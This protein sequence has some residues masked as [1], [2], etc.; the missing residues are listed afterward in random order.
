MV[1]KDCLEWLRFARMD[2]TAAQDLYSKQQN[3]RHRPIEIILYHSQQGAEKALK[4]FIIQQVLS[5]E[6][7]RTH[8]LQFLRKTCTKWDDS[9]SKPRVTKHCALLDPFS[10]TIRYPI[11]NYPLDSA[12]ALRGLNSAKRVFNFVCGRL[13]LDVSHMIDP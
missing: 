8:D 1:S 5:I 7:L 4:A 3:P 10:V 12:L 13:N 11:H 9:F 2:I 6:D